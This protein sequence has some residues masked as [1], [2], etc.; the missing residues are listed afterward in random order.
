MIV[1]T[2]NI[3]VVDFNLFCDF[4]K[5]ATKIV[6]SAKILLSPAG[7]AIYGARKPFARCELQTSAV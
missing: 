2:C 6:D 4:V 5:T 7:A 1:K 3:R